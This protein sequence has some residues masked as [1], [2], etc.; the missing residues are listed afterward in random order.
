MK[1]GIVKETRAEERRVAASPAVVAKWVKGGWEVAVERGAGADAS[2]PDAQYAAAGAVVVDRDA[3]WRG[4][5]VLKLRPP[6]VHS[7]GSCEADQMREGA[8]LIA[9][10]MPAE[11]PELVEKL[12]ARRLTVL[13][14][15]Q[16]PRI[17]R[18]QKMDALSSM[19]NIAG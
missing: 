12:A 15:D 3:A 5:I 7:D 8:T 9:Y 18:A 6:V 17:S 10:I 11:N 14:M 1:L 13:A 19:A 16:V 2:Y 4:D